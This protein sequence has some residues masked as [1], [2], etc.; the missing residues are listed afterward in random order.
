MARRGVGGMLN[1]VAGL[2]VIVGVIVLV[3][4]GA[5]RFGPALASTF[6]GLGTSGAFGS[7]APMGGGQFGPSSSPFAALGAALT[8]PADA[9]LAKP[10]ESITVLDTA[11]S[12]YQDIFRLQG[13]TAPTI[14]EAIARSLP[15]GTT[16]DPDPELVRTSTG[17]T[18]G[19]GAFGIA[20]NQRLLGYG[21]PTAAFAGGAPIFA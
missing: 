1:T 7:A 21:E 3:A 14:T 11:V 9:M 19:G 18:F 5:R 17:F 8:A 6:S 10:P 4:W 15:R 20:A 16:T 13:K 12:R 2:L